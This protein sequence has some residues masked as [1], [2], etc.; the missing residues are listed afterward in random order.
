MPIPIP[1][2]ATRPRRLVR[3]RCSVIVV[4]RNGCAVSLGLVCLVP[5]TFAPTAETKPLWSTCLCKSPG[6]VPIFLIAVMSFVRVRALPLFLESLR[7][8]QVTSFSPVLF[9]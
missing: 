4:V 7:P 9:C 1:T 6:H 8:Q 5:G 2:P 3:D